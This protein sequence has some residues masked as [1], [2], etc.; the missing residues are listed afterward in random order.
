MHPEVKKEIPKDPIDRRW[1]HEL[2]HDA[3][4]VFWLLLY[5][6][7]G[8]QPEGFQEEPINRVIWSGLTGPATSRN[9]LVKS[10]LNDATHSAYERLVPLLDNLAAILAV[11]RHWLEPPDPRNDPEYLNEA[12]Q[13][14]ILRFILDNRG[15]EFMTYKV[16]RHPRHPD[17]S[18]EHL[19]PSW[20]SGWAIHGENNR[21]R[22]TPRRPSISQGETK[23]VRINETVDPDI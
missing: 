7:V 19:S 9:H 15:E 14:L 17:L 18:S 13:R 6:A 11:D 16:A 1:R 2:D 23:R 20:S 22:P 3:E 8:A 21:K 12:F 4:S 5:W 10:E